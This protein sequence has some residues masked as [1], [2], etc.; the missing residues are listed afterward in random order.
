MT[1]YNQLKSE[2][3][4]DKIYSLSEIQTI[5]NNKFNTNKKSIIPSDYCYN[6]LNKGIKFDKHIFIYLERNR[7]KY[8]EEDYKYAGKVYHK[9]H[10]SSLEI[11]V[12]EWTNGK[13]S[14]TIPKVEASARRV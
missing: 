14:I 11:V 4:I 12:G 7:Y 1:I 3:I 6:R 9:P 2:L 10:K 13:Y 5:L 8:V